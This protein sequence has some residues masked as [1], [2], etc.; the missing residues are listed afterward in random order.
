MRG[1]RPIRQYST[2]GHLSAHG[3]PHRPC[4]IIPRFHAA[5]YRSRPRS[6]SWCPLSGDWGVVAKVRSLPSARGPGTSVEVAA[7]PGAW[8]GV[9]KCAG[10]NAG[11]ER[12]WRINI[13][14]PAT[15]QRCRCVVCRLLDV[16][17]KDVGGVSAEQHPAIVPELSFSRGTA[18]PRRALACSVRPLPCVPSRGPGPSS[19]V[20][21]PEGR[22]FAP[23]ARQALRALAWLRGLA[24]LP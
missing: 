13:A 1:L 14:H 17:D 24:Q 15:K 16:F 3:M 23:M 11:A 9:G 2:E 8:R 10:G 4:L 19:I 20:F 22:G 12:S 18:P 6:P 7:A 21:S 5:G